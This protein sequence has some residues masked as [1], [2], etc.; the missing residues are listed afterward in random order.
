VK[1]D[2]PDPPLADERIL[3]RPLRPEDAS[4]VAVACRDSEIVRW[5]TQIPPGYTEEHASGWIA[6][7]QD[8]WA[9][10]TADLAVIERSSSAFVGA[11]GLVV[12]EPWLGEIGF[13]TAAP[14][15]GCGYT[16]RA[17]KLVTEW[18][19][20][21]GLSR[22]QLTILVG[23]SASERVAEKVGYRR[24]GS[25]RAYANQRDE[26]RDVTLWARISA[27]GDG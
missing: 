3:L 26:L 9:K 14:F 25:L 13:W 19:L 10:G 8:G 24:E 12:R 7:T 5:T 4:A 17:L 22:L 23:N 15:R 6:W 21:L 27:D 1:L 16:T 20:K 11:V 2:P 18:G